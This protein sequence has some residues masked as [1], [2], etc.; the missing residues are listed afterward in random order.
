MKRQKRCKK[1]AGYTVVSETHTFYL[2]EKYLGAWNFECW[3]IS[4][5][6]ISLKILL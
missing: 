4:D 6:P 2:E 1:W 5:S 3:L